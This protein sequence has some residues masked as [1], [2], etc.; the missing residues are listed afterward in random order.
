MDDYYILV[1][2]DRVPADILASVA[3]KAQEV[4]L[5]LN[6]E[7]TQICPLTKPFKY[8]KA[9]YRLKENG[10]IIVNGNRDSVRRCRRKIKL[11]H[12]RYENGT[13]TLSEIWQALQSSFAYF[14]GYNDHGRI[15]RLRRLFYALF[16]FSIEK[17]EFFKEGVS[18]DMWFTDDSISDVYVDA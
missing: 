6:M 14:E 1:P 12:E 7:K 10:R 8:C 11:F 9:T 4:G 18:C 3:E 16:G 5:T 17:R 13:M 15:L 2:P